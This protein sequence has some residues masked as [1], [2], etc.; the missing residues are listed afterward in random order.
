MLSVGEKWSF[1]LKTFRCSVKNIPLEDTKL[2]YS[3]TF[4]HHFNQT[5]TIKN[6]SAII[7]SLQAPEELTAN[8]CSLGTP[9]SFDSIL[10]SKLSNIWTQRQS[11]KGEFGSTYKTTELTI[12]AANIFT[13]GGFRGLLI[14]LES[15]EDIT[16]ESFDR[17]VNNIRTLLTKISITDYKISNDLMN[18]FKPN[19]ICDLAYQYLK[20]LE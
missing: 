4:S 17:R 7:T 8:G 12:R 18:K 2:M 5:I 1:E 16:Q 13:Y 9:E 14:E 3:I 6:N 20:V 11:T 10:L 19:F 15:N